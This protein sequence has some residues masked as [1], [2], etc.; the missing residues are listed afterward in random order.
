MTQNLLHA[1]KTFLEGKFRAIKSYLKKQEK[2]QINSLTVHL[3]QLE[4]K[5]ETKPKVN[6][7][8]ET[9]KITAEIN[10]IE[11]KKTIANINEIKS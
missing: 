6:T 4:K 10:E 2:S 9:I 11:E 1:V 5:E 7:R 8:K 3:K